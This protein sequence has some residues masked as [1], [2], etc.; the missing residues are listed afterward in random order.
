MLSQIKISFLK[1]SITLSVTYAFL[2]IVPLQG[3]GVTSTHGIIADSSGRGTLLK[4]DRFRIN[5]Q[6][7]KLPPSPLLIVTSKTLMALRDQ[8]QNEHDKKL[9]KI[10][11]DEGWSEFGLM[12]NIEGAVGTLAENAVHMGGLKNINKTLTELGLFMT[13]WQV[14]MDLSRGDNTAAGIN[15]Y[16]GMM[17]YA[18]GKFGWTNLQ[19]ASVA[20]LA[21]DIALNEFGTEAWLARTDAWRQSYTA[22]YREE[23]SKARASEYGVQK[24]VPDTHEEMIAKIRK[25]KTG[26]RSINQWKILLDYYYKKAETAKRFK[27]LVANEVD[28][29]VGRYW[30]SDEYEGMLTGYRQTAVGVAPGTSLT[31]EIKTKLEN[32]HRARL[33]AMFVV[34]I[35]PEIARSAWLKALPAEVDR[36]NRVLKPEL[37]DSYIV[38]VSAYGLKGSARFYITKPAGGKWVGKIAQGKLKRFRMT[39]F[40]YIRAGMPDK[41]T[42]EGPNGVVEKPLVFKNGKATVVFGKPT[43]PQLVT[44]LR[45]EESAQ[46]CRVTRHLKNGKT[47]TEKEDRAARNTLTIDQ[48]VSLTGNNSVNVIFGKYDPESGQWLKASSG[49]YNPSSNGVEFTA[50]Y[51]DNIHRLY[52]CRTKESELMEWMSDMDCSFERIYISRDTSGTTTESKCVS[53]VHIKPKGVYVKMG[54]TMKF[55]SFEGEAGESIRQSMRTMHKQMNKLKK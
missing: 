5:P 15:S 39:K 35:F 29:Y 48:S 8:T 28:R 10:A 14:S 20:I 9:D 4:V 47:M 25:Q 13:V 45:T 31:D 55:F 2:C 40:A 11:C 7:Y 16:K 46:T 30:E 51:L 54:Q 37:N 52:D 26:G 38:E 12:F 3:G 27:A 17:Y 24:I 23:E 41:V 42:L 33:M 18:I 6:V 43:A 36:L 22:Y 44:T 21:I 1:I 19:I 50:P 32:E 49:I 53:Q 34:K